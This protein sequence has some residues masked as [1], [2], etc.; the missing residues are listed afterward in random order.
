M[1][2]RKGFHKRNT[3]ISNADFISWTDPDARVSKK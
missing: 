2:G 3:K 1:Q